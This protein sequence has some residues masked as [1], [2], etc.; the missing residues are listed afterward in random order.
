MH[1]RVATIV[2]VYP[3][4]PTAAPSRDTLV[5]SVVAEERTT[6]EPKAVDRGQPLHEHDS[7]DRN[8]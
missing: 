3:R 1:H 2:A 6:A 7:A 5:L 8:R 4:W